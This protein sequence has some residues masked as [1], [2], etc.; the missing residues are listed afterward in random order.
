MDKDHSEE[1]EFESSSLAEIAKG[2]IDAILLS[3]D[4]ISKH[5]PW[6]WLDEPVQEHLLK[7]ARHAVSHQ[8]IR[9]GLQKDDGENHLN[10]AICRLVMALAK[11]LREKELK[12]G[13]L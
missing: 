10:L 4:R 11:E 6:T 3:P 8:L 13:H 5:P 9:Q 12:D 1:F 2:A 7:G